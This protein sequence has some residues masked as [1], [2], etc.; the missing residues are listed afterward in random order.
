MAD[1]IRERILQAVYNAVDGATTAAVYRSRVDAL[2]RRQAP[3]LVVEPARDQVQDVVSNCKLD[4]ALSVLVAV[5][6]RGAAP[7][8]LA[9]PI[10]RDIHAA[11]MADRSLGGIAMDITPEAVDFQLEP[12]DVPAGWT[13]CSYR[14]RYRTG[15]SDL[16]A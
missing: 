15:I 13:V 14:V 8:Q 11:A 2:S 16:T 1:T 7:D 5:Y 12:G 3:A 6:T 4:W 10:I 9:D